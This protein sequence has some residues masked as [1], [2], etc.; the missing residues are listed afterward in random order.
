M[1][2]KDRT[3]IRAALLAVDEK[4]VSDSARLIRWRAIACG[5]FFAIAAAIWVITGVPLHGLPFA[6]A[7][8]MA[9]ILLWDA[10]SSLGYAKRRIARARGPSEPPTSPPGERQQRSIQVD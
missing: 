2:E 3:A 5:G 6:L 9:G 4:L 8:V 10:W 1:A 7:A